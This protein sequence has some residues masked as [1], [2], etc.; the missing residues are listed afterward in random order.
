MIVRS[1]S[2]PMAETFAISEIDVAG[3]K[4]MLTTLATEKKHLVYFSLYDPDGG[5]S[6]AG[7][8]STEDP[9]LGKQ[10][11]PEIL[12]SITFAPKDSA[13]KAETYFSQG[14]ALTREGKDGEAQYAFLNA[15]FLAP[16]KKEY[17]E[18]IQA[19]AKAAREAFPSKKVQ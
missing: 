2:R 12:A 17:Q 7:Y 3:K 14:E 1:I 19:L 6:F 4:G 13:D 5:Q 15:L 8:I 18:R 9:N 11:V 10:L 16:D